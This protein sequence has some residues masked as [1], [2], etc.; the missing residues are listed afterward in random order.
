MMTVAGNTSSTQTVASSPDFLRNG[1][2]LFRQE[3][4]IMS[5]EHFIV[6]GSKEVT[7]G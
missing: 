4:F 6:P 7:Q 3:I 5:L 1:Q 2:F